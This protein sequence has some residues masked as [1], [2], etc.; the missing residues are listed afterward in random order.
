MNATDMKIVEE[1]NKILE[2]KT[3]KAGIHDFNGHFWVELEDGTIYDDY[4]WEDKEDFRRYFGIKKN[5]TLEYDKCENFLT[6]KLVMTMLDR[7]LTQGGLPLEEAKRLFGE[8]WIS[9]R[10]SCMFNATAN[11]Y[12]MGGKVVFGCVYMNSDCGKKR[13][14][15]CGGENFSTFNDFKKEHDH[16]AK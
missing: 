8:N 14:Y 12:K 10:L 5:N 15:I 9:C 2:V 11:Q 3:D 6:Y 16:L 4:N 7:T 1:I 13:R